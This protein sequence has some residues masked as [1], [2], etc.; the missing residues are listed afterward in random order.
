MPPLSVH[1]QGSLFQLHTAT[2]VYIAGIAV[3]VCEFIVQAPL[4][5]VALYSP[6]YPGFVFTTVAMSPFAVVFQLPLQFVIHPAGHPAAQET[7][8][9]QQD[10]RCS[11]Y[12]N[13]FQ[14]TSH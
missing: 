3:H 1:F 7:G 13:L 10:F 12:P 6:A 4:L 2:T 11:L 14:C 9:G 8:A 5:Q